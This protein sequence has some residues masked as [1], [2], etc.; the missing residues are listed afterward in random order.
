[1]C[2]LR[3]FVQN[4]VEP[5]AQIQKE[6]KEKNEVDLLLGL[7]GNSVS[8]Q[9]H[10]QKTPKIACVTLPHFHKRTLALFNGMQK[11]AKI[12]VEFL[13]GIF[14]VRVHG[15][16]YVVAPNILGDDLRK[17]LCNLV[18]APMSATLRLLPK[19]PLQKPK[20]GVLP[21]TAVKDDRTLQRIIFHP[22]WEHAQRK[23]RGD[24][25]RFCA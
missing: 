3:L 14:T 18:G 12:P 23:P 7:S 8:K 9:E 25:N 24:G 5:F 17:K 10:N 2:L 1:M 21:G 15:I 6:T 4:V 11:F 16:P 20:A 13:K 22:R 19:N